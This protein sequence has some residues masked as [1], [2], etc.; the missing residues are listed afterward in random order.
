MTVFIQALKNSFKM[1]QKQAVFSLNKVRM[2]ITVFYLFILLA[3]VSIPALVE[4]I[5]TD[6]ISSVQIHPFFLLIYFFIIYYLILVLLVFIA[7]S[8]IAYIGKGLAHLLQRKLHYSIL[9]KMTAFSST[10]PFLLFTILSFLFAV[11]TTYVVLALIYVLFVLVK[12]IL[13]Y[14]KK[15]K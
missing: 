9:W 6:P 7:I 2:D 3:I 5:V 12:V 1:P 13:I 11:P 8:I 14:P 15:S 4:Q 10:I